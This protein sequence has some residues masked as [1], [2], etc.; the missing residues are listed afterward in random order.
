MIKTI[1]HSYITSKKCDIRIFFNTTE[2]AQAVH[3]IAR[4][5]IS[6]AQQ[7]S[8][9]NPPTPVHV[10]VYYFT[11]DT[12]RRDAY[13][14]TKSVKQGVT[15]D[16][17]LAALE[18]AEKLDQ[19]SQTASKSLHQARSHA[20]KVH[21]A[22]ANH[23]T[24]KALADAAASHLIATAQEAATQ[25]TTATA[26][27]DVEAASAA[28]EIARD[29]AN[30]ATVIVAGLPTMTPAHPATSPPTL[31]VAKDAMEVTEPTGATPVT[32][33][34]D[35]FNYQGAS[36]SITIASAP[37]LQDSTTAMDVAHTSTKHPPPPS[38]P[39]RLPSNNEEATAA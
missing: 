20:K 14:A 10:N 7:T 27:Q 28:T 22:A 1:R 19:A 6:G 5:E 8:M 12:A 18:I 37:T 39:P 34:I 26:V 31:P 21:T 9:S 15:I 35:P 33:A 16:E 3:D 36:S 17:R 25:A 13:Y 30:A 2:A 24:D 29:A 32:P 38:P 23:P 11:E 4:K